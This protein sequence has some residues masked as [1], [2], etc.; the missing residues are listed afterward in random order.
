MTM[1]YILSQFD[2]TGLPYVTGYRD[3]KSDPTIPPG[4]GNDTPYIQDLT[5]T[6]RTIKGENSRNS[7]LPE[8]LAGF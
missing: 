5:H 8:V 1:S 6:K 3:S 7:T 2:N 4:Q